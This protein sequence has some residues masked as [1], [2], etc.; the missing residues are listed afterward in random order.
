V[1]EKLI[2]KKRNHK[3]VEKEK[4]KKNHPARLKYLLKK[5]TPKNRSK[6]A[7]REYN[8]NARIIRKYTNYYSK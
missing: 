6:T 2:I 4:I 8:V 7:L 5:E 3:A 1:N